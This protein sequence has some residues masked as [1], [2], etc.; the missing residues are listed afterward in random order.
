MTENDSANPSRGRGSLPFLAHLAYTQQDLPH[1]SWNIPD[2]LEGCQPRPAV[3]RP[4]TVLQHSQ[5]L[6]QETH[7]AKSTSTGLDVPGHSLE[8]S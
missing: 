7:G 3:Q 2:T 8:P 4:P 1:G 5:L 6:Q